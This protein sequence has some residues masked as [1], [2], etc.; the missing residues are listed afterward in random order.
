[1]VSSPAAELARICTAATRVSLF[2]NHPMMRKI[3]KLVFTLFIANWILKIARASRYSFRGK[4]VLITGGSRGLGLVLARRLGAEGARLVLVARDAAELERAVAE[5]KARGISTLA[6][7]CDVRDPAAAETAIA[8]ALGEFGQLDVL[9]N[10]AGIILVGPLEN[11]AFED[12]ES[13]FATHVWAPLRWMTAALP[14]LKKTRGRIVNISSIGGKIAVPHLAPY[15]ASKFALA[16]LSDAFRNELAKDGIKVTSVFPGLLRTGSHIRARFKGRRAAE[17]A[18]F[19]MGSATPLSSASAE[20]AAAQIV[21]ACRAGTPQLIITIQAR[22]AVLAASLFPNST[23]RILA[24]VNRFLPGIG[25]AGEA[26]PG[27][28]ARGAFPPKLATF[29]P[30]QASRANNEL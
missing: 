28:A 3:L 4:V 25:P 20:R 29:L 13:A 1:M 14:H 21:C 19:A 22:L 15:S 6:V 5:Q 27:S 16:G 18:W 24:L 7:A 9:I 10:N 23:A 26:L 12:Y 17:F 2:K 11:M 30:D 8:A